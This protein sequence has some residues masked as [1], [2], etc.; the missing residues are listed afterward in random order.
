MAVCMKKL[1]KYLL[2]IGILNITLYFLIITYGNV[3]KNEIICSSGFLQKLFANKTL[4]R[5]QSKAK[6]DFKSFE[7]IHFNQNESDV[8]DNEKVK[9]KQDIRDISHDH[10]NVPSKYILEDTIEV[11]YASCSGNQMEGFHTQDLI[12]ALKTLFL[13]NPKNIRVHIFVTEINRLFLEKLIL[14]WQNIFPEQMDNISL[15]PTNIPTNITFKTD[16]VRNRKLAN[17]SRPIIWRDLFRPCSSQ[18]IFIPWGL[19]QIDKIIY[20]DTDTIVLGSLRNLWNEFDKFN[21]TQAVGMAPIA[22]HP[23]PFTALRK[24]HTIGEFGHNAGVLLMRLDRLRQ[25]DWRSEM[26]E[27]GT[28]I[29]ETVNVLSDQDMINTYLY[30]HRQL[31]YE[32]SCMYN[33]RDCMCVEM[34]NFSHECRDADTYGI[35]IIHGISDSF[36]KNDTLLAPL[37]QLFYKFDVENNQISDLITDIE[38]LSK[39]NKNNKMKCADSISIFHRRIDKEIKNLLIQ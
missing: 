13:F 38:M 19:P 29:K 6:M 15:Y 1:F 35:N 36:H 14:R 10:F 16:N 9:M 20:L 26:Q 39:L 32:L 31:F 27:I 7:N 4:L 18:R 37:F 11:A 22:F 34:Q 28:Q 21:D 12:V 33:F 8:N 24:I 30:Y 23:L 5:F 2:A 3:C 17:G 25:V